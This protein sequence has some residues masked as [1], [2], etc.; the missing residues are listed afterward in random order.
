MPFSKNMDLWSDV[1]RV[2]AIEMFLKSNNIYGYISWPA[3]GPDMLT[4][5]FF[6]W[7]FLKSRMFQTHSAELLSLKLRILKEQNVL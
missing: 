4:C 6:V 2:F 1:C 3:P 7:V 5:D